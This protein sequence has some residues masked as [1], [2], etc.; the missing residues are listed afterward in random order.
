VERDRLV[1]ILAVVGGALVLVLALVI[2]ALVTNHSSKPSASNIQ[3]DSINEMLSGVPQ[4]GFELGNPK[5]KLTL[6]EFVDP[7]CPY[8]GEWSRT[9]LPT[10]VQSYVRT[11]KL[12][13]EYRGL[14]FVGDD[15][16]RL[17]R[18][19]LA[20]GLQNKLWNVVE[21]EFENQGTENSGYATDALMRAIVEAVPGLDAKKALATWNTSAV[22]PLIESAKKLSEQSFKEVATPSFLLG[23]TGAKPTQK[24]TN[25]IDPQSFISAINAQLSK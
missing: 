2:G 7:Q 12:R 22:V 6:V 19:A 20:A 5:A 10:L 23:P 14:A 25:T 15:S 13:I 17:L 18:L 16:D 9:V 3:L 8:C 4:H 21:L 24:I 11:G 1:P